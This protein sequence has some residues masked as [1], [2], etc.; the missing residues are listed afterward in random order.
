MG[1]VSFDSMFL[2][3]YVYKISAIS[4]E[5][6]RRKLILKKIIKTKL[7]QNLIEFHSLILSASWGFGIN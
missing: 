3:F 1:L 4:V 5:W 2:V 6:Y 7:I